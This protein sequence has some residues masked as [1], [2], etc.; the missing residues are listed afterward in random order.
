MRIKIDK[1][2]IIMAMLFI[3][4]FL[5]FWKNFFGIVNQEEFIDFG[6]Y[7]D[8]YPVMDLIHTDIFGK[9]TMFYS[10]RNNVNQVGEW[11]FGESADILINQKYDGLTGDDFKVYYSQIGLGSILYSIIF[12]IFGNAL[13]IKA[14]TLFTAL[15]NTTAIFIVIVWL[16]KKTN[17][18]TGLAVISF[19]IFLSPDLIKYGRTFYWVLWTWFIPMISSIYVLGSKTYKSK[20]KYLWSGFITFAACLFRFMFNYEFVSVVLIAMICPYIYYYLKKCSFSKK[21]TKLKVL[22]GIKLLGAPTVGGIIAFIVSFIIKVI[23]L[24]LISQSWKEA[25]KLSQEASSEAIKHSDISNL[26]TIK[27]YLTTQW[28]EIGNIKI[29]YAGLI[30]LCTLIIFVCLAIIFYKEKT[31]RKY[32]PL[33]ITTLFSFCAP[34]SWMILATVHCFYPIHGIYIITLW[35][36]PFLLFLVAT[37]FYL[38]TNVVILLCNKN[39]E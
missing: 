20:H 32:I 29:T 5:S 27:L 10:V 11:T 22:N 3:L 35:Y 38:S 8:R 23:E 31:I 34:I 30:I 25:F 6:T 13:S 15:M 1:K 24:F 36:V 39:G 12:F 21:K 37:T 26:E 4:L 17:F 28:L 2:I 9:N 7:S 14:I 33:S 19:V 18:L 16:Q